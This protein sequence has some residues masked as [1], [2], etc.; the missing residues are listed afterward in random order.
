MNESN[1]KIRLMKADDFDA[2]VGIAVDK[3]VYEPFKKSWRSKSK[4]PGRQERYRTDA[5][6][7]HEPVLL[8]G[9]PERLGPPGRYGHRLHQVLVGEVQHALHHVDV[10][11]LLGH[12]ALLLL[13]RCAESLMGGGTTRGPRSPSR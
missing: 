4:H 1:I 8:R 12:V 7:Q 3:R 5:F 6:L 2:V 9:V 13:T 11:L 10:Y